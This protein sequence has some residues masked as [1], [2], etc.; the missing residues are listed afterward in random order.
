MRQ[1]FVRDKRLLA[2]ALSCGVAFAVLTAQAAQGE[3]LVLDA[4][5]RVTL[6]EWQ[7]PLLMSTMCNVTTLGGIP[8]LPSF[9]GYAAALGAIGGAMIFGLREVCAA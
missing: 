3:F 6:A 7:H 4:P 9:I 8:W 5:V 1:W 2:F